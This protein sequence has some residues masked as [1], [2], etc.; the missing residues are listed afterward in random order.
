MTVWLIVRNTEASDRIARRRSHP[1]GSSC[2]RRRPVSIRRR[3]A[4]SWEGRTAAFRSSWAS[5]RSTSPGTSRSGDIERTR[6]ASALAVALR[7]TADSQAAPTGS[8]G[9]RL[10]A[11]ERARVESRCQPW[12]VRLHSGVCRTRTLRRLRVSVIAAAVSPGVVAHADATQYAVATSRSCVAPTTGALRIALRTVT[13]I[14]TADSA[15][16]P[17][18]SGRRRAGDGA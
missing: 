16:W 18:A 8:A 5:R 6:F 10:S 15:N 14:L 13:M 7:H 11:S 1:T 4:N 2:R 9:D 3:D 12:L 17:V